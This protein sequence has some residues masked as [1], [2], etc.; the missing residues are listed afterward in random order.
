[1]SYIRIEREGDRYEVCVTNPEVE[2][3][4]RTEKGGW[5][6]PNEEY[7]FDTWDQVKTFLDKVVDKA[8]PV[9]EYSSAFSKAAK[10]S[11][12]A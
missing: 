6:D 7:Q 4:N 8:L 2:K 9:D 5:T 11:Q 12:N 3:A 1:M 10:E